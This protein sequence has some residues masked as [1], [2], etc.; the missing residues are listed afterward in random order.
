MH[1]RR[2][3]S[4]LQ[5]TKGGRRTNLRQNPLECGGGG[6]LGL[7]TLACVITEVAAGERISGRHLGEDEVYDGGDGLEGGGRRQK[8]QLVGV[9]EE[10]VTR[11]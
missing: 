5:V 3:Y 2:P 6:G 10:C 1:K 4:I 7:R 8:D 11:K 9:E